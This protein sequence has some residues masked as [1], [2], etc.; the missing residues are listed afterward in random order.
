M[1]Y[2]IV[3]RH[4][5]GWQHPKTIFAQ[6]AQIHVQYSVRCHKNANSFLWNRQLAACCAQPT[7][8][9]AIVL[10]KWLAVSLCR[11]LFSLF[12]NVLFLG[13]T[14]RCMPVTM[15][16]NAMSLIVYRDKNA[17]ER[18]VTVGRM[19]NTRCAYELNATSTNQL[20]LLSI[21]CCVTL[22]QVFCGV[23]FFS[24]IFTN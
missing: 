2:S 13:N 10:L 8:Y 21:F 17:K 18:Y 23:V 12:S 11:H 6:F 14:I 4:L 19:P 9:V 1:H 24:V 15:G 22:I 3:N 5:F 7:D 20:L 16:H